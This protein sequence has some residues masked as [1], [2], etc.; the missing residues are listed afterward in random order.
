MIELFV[1]ALP[2]PCFIFCNKPGVKIGLQCLFHITLGYNWVIGPQTELGEFY[3]F[4]F[5][6]SDIPFPDSTTNWKW[7]WSI[8]ENRKTKLAKADRGLGVKGIYIC[9]TTF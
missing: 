6:K 1:E 4:A 7:R 8:K 9:F 5:V 3:G 2:E